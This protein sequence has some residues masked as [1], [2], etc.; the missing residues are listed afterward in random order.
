MVPPYCCKRFGLLHKDYGTSC[1]INEIILKIMLSK[2]NVEQMEALLS[3]ELLGRIGCSANGV[4]YIVPVHYVYEAPFIYAHSARGMKVD[5][6]RE[7]PKVCFEVDK[8]ANYFNWQSVICWGTFEEITDAHESQEALQL[9]IDRIEP[10]LSTVQ[11][12]HH[13]HGISERASDIGKD[14]KLVVYRIRLH[15]KTGRFE[16]QEMIAKSDQEN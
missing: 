15:K 2:L 14:T 4:N 5:I 6:M 7:N 12:T 1:F 16:N 9:L 3:D 11:D 10:H 8:V 13:S